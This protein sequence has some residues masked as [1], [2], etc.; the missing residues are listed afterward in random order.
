MQ[1]RGA[2]FLALNPALAVTL[3]VLGMP[4]GTGGGP[5]AATAAVASSSGEGA[6][7]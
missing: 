6:L 7:A 5:A 4:S 2:I 1:F 3:V